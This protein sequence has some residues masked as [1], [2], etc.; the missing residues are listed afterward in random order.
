MKAAFFI[1]CTIIIGSSIYWVHS[2]QAQGP[3]ADHM[4]DLDSYSL[5]QS[6]KLLNVKFA[7]GDK[8]IKFS[9]T[10]AE[11]A[12]FDLSTAKIR[13]SGV[14][15]KNKTKQL[16]IIRKDDYF[17]IS[18]TPADHDVIEVEVEDP[19]TK[20]KDKFKFKLNLR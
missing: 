14:S 13:A 20:K 10:G 3:G 2:V 15:K 16:S 6:P 19:K 17:I 4:Q 5:I 11:K 8:K 7:P 12:E 18:E 9:L 1:L